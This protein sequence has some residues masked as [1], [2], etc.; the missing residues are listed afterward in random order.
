MKSRILEISTSL[1]LHVRDVNSLI[2]ILIIND[3]STFAYNAY[4]REV[5]KKK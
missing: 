3:D 2:C 5:M 1:N 4:V